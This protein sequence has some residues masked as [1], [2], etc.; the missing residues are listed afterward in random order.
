MIA[1]KIMQVLGSIFLS[2]KVFQ[3]KLFSF[4]VGLL[5]IFCFALGLR[6][7]SLDRFATLVF[8]EVY[9]AQFAYNYLHQIP[10][11]DNHP[12]LG[13]YCIALGLWS[14]QFIQGAIAAIAQGLGWERGEP[15]VTVV[16]GFQ[17]L[18]WGYRWLNAAVGALLPLLGAALAYELTQRRTYALI[19]AVLLACD[20]LLLVESRYA[21]INIYIM[22]F[23]LLGQWLF[24]RSLRFQ[25]QRDSDLEPDPKNNQKAGLGLLGTGIL[26]G[27]AIAV[28]WNG[29]GFI[30]GLG[31]WWGLVWLGQYWHGFKDWAWGCLGQGWGGAIDRGQSA[32]LSQ[33]RSRPDSRLTLFSPYLQRL[34]WPGVQPR[35]PRPNASFQAPTALESALLSL[36]WSDFVVY[37]GIVP[38]LLYR[39]V[40]VPH[41]WLNQDFSFWQNQAQGL[42]SHASVGN[43]Q[44]IHPY[45]SAWWGWPWLV[46]PVAYWYQT[47][48]E[49]GIT[50]VYD[51][52]ALG[53]P[54]LWWFSSLTVVL[55]VLILLRWLWIEI[56]GTIYVYARAVV[57]LL[58]SWTAVQA[59]SIGFPSPVH[60]LSSVPNRPFPA[61]ALHPIDRQLL[62]FL[63]VNLGAN[64]LPWVEVQR[65]LFLYHYMAASIYSFLLLAWLLDRWFRSR[66]LGLQLTALVILLGIFWGL[67]YWLPIYLGLPL[68]EAAFRSRMWFRSWY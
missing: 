51:V 46:R 24:L 43:G 1:S 13:K 17:G 56:Y 22:L 37:L 32:Q 19:A 28:K 61:L 30:L 34:R 60:R 64:W 25:R 9:F 42:F 63:L 29:L 66:R 11:F 26:L 3:S 54:M 16:E 57:D 4:R 55:T 6:F 62:T 31:G 21:L 20:G 33:G 45:C 27:S 67:L 47:V 48:T 41:L 10:F 5:S 50:W 18:T 39:L 38:F 65:C 44:D 12:P 35:S 68:E 14:S 49:G 15:A 23:G 58:Q 59:R 8:D 40:W 53:N 2:S 52:H 36:H 7:W